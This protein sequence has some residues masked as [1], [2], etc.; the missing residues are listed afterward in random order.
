MKYPKQPNYETLI[1]ELVH[2]SELKHEYGSRGVK[3][4]IAKTEKALKQS[5][6]E[7]KKLPIDKNLA[8]KEPDK[9]EKIKQ[10]RPKGPRKIWQNFDREKYLD[11][12]EGAFLGRIAGCTLGAPVELWPIKK[13]RDLAKENGQTFPPEDYWSYVPD[14]YYKRYEKTPH[15]NYTRDKI[16]CAPVDDDI[17]YTIIGLLVVEECGLNFTTKDVAAVWDKY[18]PMAL[19]A[20]GVA[21]RNFRAGVPIDQVAEKDNP[22]IQWIGAYI[23]SDP[24]GYI[25]AGWPQRAAE[26]AYQDAYLSHRRQGIYGEMFFAATIAAAFTVDDPMDALKIGLT[27]IPAQSAMAKTV[28]WAL[29]EASSIKNYKQARAAVENRFTQGELNSRVI[30]H[31]GMHP[32]HTL[33]NACLT[34]W[35]IKIGGRDFSRVISETVAMGLDNDCTGATAGSIVGA[36][37]GKK[38]IPAHWYERFNNKVDTYLIGKGKM[39]ISGL[40]KRFAK[41]AAEVYKQ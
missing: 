12:V 24:W 35:G 6:L 21:L 15:E 9:L 38:A 22:F 33:N 26:M 14:P 31:S 23:R 13:M 28:R 25:A 3:Q 20:E 2:Y 41:Q 36:V 18:L 30:S 34:I 37:I 29:N 10:L 4:I 32:V 19:T 16:V 40:V 11:R 5:I 17:V 1:R 27:E 7:L 8:L 39:S